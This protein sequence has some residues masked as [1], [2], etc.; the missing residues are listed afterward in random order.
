M[1]QSIQQSLKRVSVF[2]LALVLFIGGLMPNGLVTPAHAGVLPIKRTYIQTTIDP[3]SWEILAGVVTW[4]AGVGGN[5]AESKRIGSTLLST[6]AS[7]TKPSDV[8]DKVSAAQK[9]EGDN[10]VK[11][12]V[13]CFP[14]KMSFSGWN[15]NSTAAD[16]NRAQLIRNSLIYDLN[17]AFK[18]VYGTNGIYKPS[19][20]TIDE[21]IQKYSDDLKAFLSKVPSGTVNG[22]TISQASDSDLNGTT[23]PDEITTAAD[24]VKIKKGS[25]TRIFQYR[26]VKGYVDERSAPSKLGLSTISSSDDA[27]YVHWGQ[28]AVEA[29]VNFGSEESL[30]VTA[31]DVYDSKPGS[32]EKAF[33]SLLGALANWVANALGLW[34]FDEIIFNSGV[35]GTL[36]YVGGV[37]PT[38]WQPTIWAFF[39]LAEVVAIGM[40]LYAI[41]YNVGRKIMST[42]DPIARASAIEQIKYLFIV[43]IVLSLLPFALPLMMDVSA[44]LTG[45]F[46]DA[47]GGKTATER[48]KNLAANSGGL[49]SVLTYILYLAALIYFNVFYVFRALTIALLIILAPIFVS[50]MALS[51]NKRHLAILWFKEFAANL[52]IQPLQALMLSFIL[53]VPA[54]GRNIESIIMA[55]VMIP[56]TNMLR[57]LFFGSSGGMAD[58]IS[59]KG[60]RAGGRTLMTMGGLGLG[61]LRGGL[62]AGMSAVDKDKNGEKEKQESEDRGGSRNPGGAANTTTNTQTKPAGQAD[63]SAG[64]A[65][66]GETGGGIGD[67]GGSIIPKGAAGGGT[68]GERV[69][70]GASTTKTSTMADQ[71]RAGMDSGAGAGADNSSGLAA[72]T[73]TDSSMTSTDV[74]PTGPS[75]D[76][77][78]APNSSTGQATSTSGS[79][80]QHRLRGGAKVAGAVAL[81]AL[82]GGMDYMGRRFFGVAPGKDGGLV[83]QLSQKLGASGGKDW[84]GQPT[85]S[86]TPSETSTDNSTH[87]AYDPTA[88]D[89]GYAQAMAHEASYDDSDSTSPFARE[90]GNRTKAGD[91]ASYTFGPKEMEKAGVRGI[92]KAG[93]G[94][95]MV[96]Y[97]MANLGA[98]DQN[99]MMQMVNMWENGSAEER[100]AMEAAGIADVQPVSKM[101]GGQEQVTGA[102][103]VYNND[104]AKQNLGIDTAPAS[105]G[106]KGYGVTTSGTQAP[107]IVPDM[108]SYMNTPQAAAS[109]ATK[110]LSDAG[111][112]VSM[113]QGSVSISSLGADS[114]ESMW[115]NTDDTQFALVNEHAK[116]NPDGGFTANIPIQEFTQAFNAPPIVPASPATQGARIAAQNMT[117]QPI[118]SQ[119]AQMEI[120]QPQPIFH[121][122]EQTITPPP[123][124]QFTQQSVV[125]QPQPVVT[126]APQTPT[127]V[128]Q[129]PQA[130]PVEVPVPQVQQVTY[131][132]PQDPPSGGP[133]PVIRPAPVGPV[134][135]TG[136]EKVV[137]Q[138]RPAQAPSVPTQTTRRSPDS[139]NDGRE[140]RPNSPKSPD[141]RRT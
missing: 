107:A 42:M 125:T 41:I 59:Q 34:N 137:V 88:P 71:A 30:Q 60:Q 105:E 54:S 82:G 106:G 73:E 49:G 136:P 7:S 109:L 18:F 93:Q 25:E 114:M 108:V 140:G 141:K 36:S 92:H 70:P 45:I 116:M 110:Q 112:S 52:F 78:Q 27:T 20:S 63:G 16:T 102:N 96:S 130:A 58:A 98:A 118:G 79:T 28:L 64:D 67:A 97:D 68:N 113:G 31:G 39:F 80:G 62:A 51:E 131:P 134:P 21:Q 139:S 86:E 24:Y 46:H 48:F 53:L 75:S 6:L 8:S 124:E 55:Y 99:R 32:I 115:L 56:L 129:T 29:F 83:T 138:S 4:E 1:S 104:T 11:T 26:M 127:A 14:G 37:F 47:L 74:S 77:T 123:I 15:D 120:S 35:R 132:A 38:S 72:G 22:A 128:T 66:P 90:I 95:S 65:K 50:L 126:P 61:A 19:G 117:A 69:D 23:F 2:L 84:R 133:A 122:G 111:V 103:V 43:A 89:G 119:P 13:L 87:N 57:Q 81:G 100:M 3:S 94:Q 17:A 85:S 40:L 135:Q 44:Q 12:L 101:V 76:G 5:Q 91:G 121:G 10:T 33:A 9:R